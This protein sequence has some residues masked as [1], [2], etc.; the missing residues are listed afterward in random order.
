VSDIRHKVLIASEFGLGKSV[1]GLAYSQLLP[2]GEDLL[3]LDYE[4]G[5]EYYIAPTREQ[6]DPSKCLFYAQRLLGPSIYEVKA[7]VRKIIDPERPGKELM[8]GRERLKPELLSAPVKQLMADIGAR[9]LNP[10]AICIDTVT[11]LCELTTN[12]VFGD[13]IARRGED[14]ADKMSQLTWAQVKDDLSELFYQIISEAHLSLIMTAWAKPRFDKV[15]RQSTQELVADVL[16]N[17][18]AFASLVLML[19]AAK[20]PKVRIPR[21]LILKSR[22]I[23]LPRGMVLERATWDSILAA[24]PQFTVSEPSNAQGDAA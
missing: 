16:K 12:R 7:I 4:D 19:E 5:Q 17:V 8:I 2:P 14:F 11:R 15:T 9:K 24:E 21:A 3:S 18:H 20:D 23:A 6:A 22:L 10:T 13:L 1:L